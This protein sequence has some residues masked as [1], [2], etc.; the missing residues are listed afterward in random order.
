M[1]TAPVIEPTPNESETEEFLDDPEVR[2]ARETL[3]DPED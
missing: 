2:A 3:D 1:S